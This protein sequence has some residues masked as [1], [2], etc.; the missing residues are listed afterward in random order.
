[1]FSQ[2]DSASKLYGE[3]I[4]DSESKYLHSAAADIP[5]SKCNNVSFMKV[6]VQSYFLN[7]IVSLFLLLKIVPWNNLCRLFPMIA[8]IFLLSAILLYATQ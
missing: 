7:I 3:I 5:D 1:M 6:E 4:L 2:N 8:G